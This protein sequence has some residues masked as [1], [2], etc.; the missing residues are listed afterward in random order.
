M[1]L[2]FSPALSLH[3]PTC[4]RCPDCLQS[5]KSRSVWSPVTAPRL[6]EQYTFSTREIVQEASIYLR[7]QGDGWRGVVRARRRAC[8]LL[9]RFPDIPR[10]RSTRSTRNHRP[11]RGF[12]EDRL[13]DHRSRL[14]RRLVCT[15]ISSSG[16]ACSRW[17]A[18]SVDPSA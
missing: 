13:W 18:R 3:P 9:E 7:W 1:F 4:H 10:T 11:K 6:W 5:R 15:A 14:L 17:I 16:T 12:Y 2:F 8:A